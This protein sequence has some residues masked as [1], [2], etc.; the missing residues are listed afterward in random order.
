ML[1]FQQLRVLGHH[2]R[3]GLVVRRRRAGLPVSQ[4]F[5]EYPPRFTVPASAIR[6]SHGPCGTCSHS[7]WIWF[8]S[9]WRN[10]ERLTYI[11]DSEQMGP[12]SHF[13]RLQSWSPC[14]FCYLFCI[15][16]INDGKAPQVCY[17]VS[18][19]VLYSGVLPCGGHPM[20]FRDNLT[21]GN[22]AR[23]RYPPCMHTPAT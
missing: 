10:T 19:P 14:M 1:D 20:R 3:P 7:G 13:Q 21:L 16:A 2:F 9:L 4:Q 11:I 12:N 15:M 22:R 5:L 23:C 17:L 18:S 6:H 8:V